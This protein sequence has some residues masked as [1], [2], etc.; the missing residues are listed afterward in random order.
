MKTKNI[1]KKISKSIL[2]AL[3]LLGLGTISCPSQ[4]KSN[5]TINR[6]FENYN[7]WFIKVVNEEGIDGAAIAIF[8]GNK[9]I[10]S[11]TYGYLD[12]S[13]DKTIN[14]E[15]IFNIQSISKTIT[16]TAVMIAAQ[17]GL[18]DLEKPITDYIPKFTVNSCFEEEPQ[19]KITMRNLLSHTAG[20][21]HEA[22]IGNNYDASLPSNEAHINSISETWLKFPVG[23]KYSYSNLGIDLAA[24][25][26]E[27]VSKIPF[28][29]FLEKE[30]F[31]PLGMN[32][33]TIKPKEILNNNNRAVGHSYGFGALPAIMP[34]YGAGAVYTSINDIVKFVQ[35]HINLGRNNNAQLLQKNY[36]LEMY[37]P[38]MVNYDNYA[39]GIAFTK[40][41]N[42]Y[43]YTHSGGGFGFGATIKWHPEYKIGV[44]VLTNADYSNSIYTIASKT[45]DDYIK[46][47]KIEIDSASIN[48]NPVECYEQLKRQKSN[49][50]QHIKCVGD[51]VFKPS[52][53]KYIG[54][55]SPIF[56]G[57]FEFKWYAKVARF[58]G[59]AK[60]KYKV[61]KKDNYLYLKNESDEK[62]FEFKP[63]LFFTP[64]GETL[65]FG[66]ESPRFRNIQLE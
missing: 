1:L 55:Y 17:K 22:P 44:V 32:A 16:A 2:L 18:I 42:S 39:L 65:D 28:P 61:Y 12:N 48:F 4:E 35:F 5:P 11:S 45:A 54:T 21:T 64:Q 3:V 46:Q 57:G 53:E 56:R 14:S 26:I 19:N 40:E 25:I 24:Y 15:T 20:F 63:G 10:W 50:N 59:F 37:K 43:A 13:S 58:F 31:L 23:S 29:D 8:D 33:T 6:P 7:N 41:G 62:L 47:N 30:L 27:R 60:Q 51:S 9:I 36:L 52:W 66:G 34:F 38:I 49:N